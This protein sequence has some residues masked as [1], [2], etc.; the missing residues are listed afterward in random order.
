M[1]MVRKVFKDSE[2]T[3]RTAVCLVKKSC[4]LI[5]FQGPG[6]LSLRLQC[7]TNTWGI[8]FYGSSFVTRLATVTGAWGQTVANTINNRAILCIV[9]LLLY[10]WT[11]CV[12]AVDCSNYC[13]VLPVELFH[14]EC[15]SSWYEGLCNLV[16]YCE[17]SFLVSDYF[18][19]Q[20]LWSNSFFKK[21]H[22]FLICGQ[23]HTIAKQC[24]G[25]CTKASSKNLKV[26]QTFMGSAL[27]F[28]L[29]TLCI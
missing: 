28:L 25:S 9:H 17:T 19:L 23:Y 4:Q 3:I 13:V 2:N 5:I 24:F 11:P 22:S 29:N 27:S 8:L 15:F 18:I 21:C 16:C 6:Y 14:W 20:H 12:Y 1:Q 7:N 26:Q 10:L